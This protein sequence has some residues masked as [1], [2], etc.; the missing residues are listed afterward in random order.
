MTARVAMR[1]RV[2]DAMVT[3]PKTLDP[4]AGVDDVRALF[5]D[6]HVHMAL[7]VAADGR[8]LT[9]IE[10]PD[11]PAAVAGETPAGKDWYRAWAMAAGY[12]F[13]RNVRAGKCGGASLCGCRGL[14]G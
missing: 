10:R 14:R 1:G 8:L 11:I 2:A 7:V 9:T 4:H 6:D 13:G 5:G 3:C 12:G